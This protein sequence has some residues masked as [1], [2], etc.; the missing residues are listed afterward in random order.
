[1][2]KTGPASFLKATVVRRRR[3][4]KTEA[5]RG[6]ASFRRAIVPR[7]PKNFKS[8]QADSSGPTSPE[9]PSRGSTVPRSHG[10]ADKPRPSSSN[11]RSSGPVAACRGRVADLEAVVAGGE[12]KTAISNLALSR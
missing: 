2:R 6:P 1:M 11:D 4:C 9:I 8:D 10:N 12:D 5:D 7:H 3:E